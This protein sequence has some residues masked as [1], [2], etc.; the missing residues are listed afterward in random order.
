M[1]IKYQMHYNWVGF[2][3]MTCSGTTHNFQNSDAVLLYLPSLSNMK[4]S[5]VEGPD[6]IVFKLS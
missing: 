6:L 2:E 1:Q 3:G 5:H 4:S